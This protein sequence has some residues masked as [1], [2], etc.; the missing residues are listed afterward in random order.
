MPFT[1]SRLGP[2][3]LLLGTAPGTEYGFQVSA[4]TLTPSVDST[5]GT[6]TLAIPTPPPE[7]KTSYSLDGSAI[8]DFA[9]AAGLQM[10]AYDQDGETV[11][12]VFTSNTNPG[13]GATV[14]GKVVV[15][16]FP[17]GGNVGEQL[18]TDFSWPC[19][20]KPVFAPVAGAT[21]A[22]RKGEK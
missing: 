6:P 22:A 2:G 5:D 21:A 16:A 10:F 11:D 17:I 7:T 14:T 12:F 19:D 1:D 3:T 18:V 4:L 9:T 8:N 15:R 20:G 13:E